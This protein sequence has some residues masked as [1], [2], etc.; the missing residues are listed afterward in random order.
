M[1]LRNKILH[2]R[3]RSNIA[4][5]SGTA[6]HI[7]LCEVHQSLPSGTYLAI[8]YRKTEWRDVLGDGRHVR[9]DMEIRFG[10]DTDPL[11]WLADLIISSN[12]PTDLRT[13]A[14]VGDQLCGDLTRLAGYAPWRRR[15][16]FDGVI[17]VDLVQA[18]LLAHEHRD[19]RCDVRPIRLAVPVLES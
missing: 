11:L 10:D 4:C 7:H 1:L 14:E 8:H 5:L 15:A 16:T 2:Q 18:R 9:Q 6:S 17:K 13:F 12:G 19:H 3:I